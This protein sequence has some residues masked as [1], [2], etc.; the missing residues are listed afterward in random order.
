MAAINMIQPAGVLPM[1]HGVAPATQEK[2]A[3]KA[4]FGQWLDQSLGEVN[5]LQ[6]ASN[7]AAQKLM[8]GEHTDIHGTMIAMQK[9]GIAMELTMEVRNKIVAAYEEIKRM[10]F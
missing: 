4:T 10:Q 6:K 1:N 5:Q 9:S 8:T 7:E 2:D 3:S